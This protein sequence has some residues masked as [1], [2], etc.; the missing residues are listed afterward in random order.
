MFINGCLS[1]WM[2]A[3]EDQLN[4]KCLAPSE[5]EDTWTDVDERQLLRGTLQEQ[6]DFYSKALGSS[7]RAKFMTENEVRDDMGMGP[8]EGGDSLAISEGT[9]DVAANPA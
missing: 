5:W 1:S 2:V 9:P 8:I 3:F 4:T 6:A 7:G